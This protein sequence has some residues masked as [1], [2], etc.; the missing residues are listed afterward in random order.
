MSPDLDFFF[1][2]V[3]PWAWITSR[4]VTEVQQLRSYDVNWRFICLAI[5][6]EENKA[7][8]YTPEY[9]A[10]HIVGLQC[11]RVADAVRLT[12][13]N[14]AVGRLYTVLG[15]AFHPGKRRPEFQESPVDFMKSA[16]ADAGLD[17]VLAGHVDDESHD[18]YIRAETELALSRTGSNLGTPIL[19]FHPGRE[20][21]GSFFGPVIPRI[22]RGDEALKLWDAIETVAITCGV[23]EM[24]RTLRGKPTFD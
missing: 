7:E 24:K 1:D 22:P 19:T 9:R 10:G 6:N 17:P 16:L 3:C 2:P 23:A 21:E 13:D 18:A 11:L 12:A 5:L 20:S 8:W 14:E 4:W 15:T